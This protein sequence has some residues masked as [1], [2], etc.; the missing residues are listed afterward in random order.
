M[1]EEKKPKTV[2]QHYYELAAKCFT[3]ELTFDQ[4]RE[5]YKTFM[6]GKP[7]LESELRKKKVV[8]LKSIAANLGSWI[9]SRHKKEDLV[10]KIFRNM[11]SCFFL[12]QN[13]SYILGKETH[14]SA[15]LKLIEAVTAE[16]LA[17]F[18]QGRRDEQA[19]KDKAVSN[20]ETIKEFREYL[21]HHGEGSLSPEQAEAYDKLVSDRTLEIRA[22][23]DEQKAMVHQQDNVSTEDFE[24]HQT[25]H[26]KTNED[27]YTVRIINRTDRDTFKELRIKAKQF[28][29]YY[30]RYTDKNATPPIYSG[31]NFDTEDKAK[32]FMGITEGD[33][34][35]KEV[36]DEVKV[37]KVQTRSEKMRERG[38]KMI[39]KAEQ[40]LNQERTTNTHRQASQAANSIAKAEYEKTFGQKLMKIADGLED[41]S[42]KYLS[43]LTNGKQIEQLEQILSHGY[44]AH[45]TYN[46]RERG[47]V[48]PNASVDV[49]Y[50]E[51][52]YPKYWHDNIRDLLL[53][54]EDKKGLKRDVAHVLDY[55]KR[56]KDEKGHVEIREERVIALFKRTGMKLDNEWDRDRV[57]NQ[58]KDYERIQKLGLTNLSLLKTAIRE[59]SELGKGTGL[60]EEEKKRKKLKE[61]ENSFIGKKIPGFFPTPRPLIDKMFSMIKV[62]D[63]DTILEPNAGLGHIA[64]AITEVYPS[65]ELSLIEFS[66]TL[67]EALRAKGYDDVEDMDFLSSTHKYDVIVMNPPFEKHQ[68]I[69]HVVHAYSLLKPGGRL[70][71]I[72]A[73]NKYEHSGHKVVREFMKFVEDMGG[74]FSQNEEGAFKS[75]FNSTGVNTTTV[76]LE[77]TEKAEVL[78]DEEKSNRLAGKGEG[79]LPSS[80]TTNEG[81][82]ESQDSTKTTVYNTTEEIF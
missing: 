63:G 42:I 54:Y 77:S 64:D 73:G 75:A 45:T 37:V 18:Y 48:S 53:P 10:E 21:A 47:K 6:D 65:N 60:S 35:S 72:M 20:P 9:D 55:L 23:E 70:V 22:K 41:G 33:Q 34:S 7:F 31:F 16:S 39:E 69:D 62:Y 52:P 44:H 43:K 76:Y 50:V 25:K 51:Y 12:N 36:Q 19:A 4:Y 1:N 66:Y 56:N 58:I 3:E 26:S 38:E 78:D 28:G 17:A 74:Y 81:A 15:S 79:W 5:N 13:V 82:N 29:G 32:L 59:L 46:D 24:L 49:N 71:A 80:T 61:I 40:S 27:I 57:L 8:Q 67:C 68:D 14:E 11:R 30:S 2:I